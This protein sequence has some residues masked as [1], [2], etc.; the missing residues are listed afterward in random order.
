MSLS[1]VL[2]FL[3]FFVVGYYI[4]HYPKQ[5]VIM[6]KGKKKILMTLCILFLILAELFVL[7]RPDRFNNAVLYGS[8]SYAAANYNWKH[9]AVLIAIGFSWMLFMFLSVPSKRIRF[10]SVLG[11]NSLP[12]FLFHGFIIKTIGCYALFCYNEVNNL[13]LSAGIAMV[14]V[15]VLGNPVTAWICKWVFTGNWIPAL[16]QQCKKHI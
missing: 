4:G 14:I 12:V 10:I 11:K 16:I 6:E 1:R 13:L 2:C 9:R 8:Y 7:S 3:P 5:S 15:L